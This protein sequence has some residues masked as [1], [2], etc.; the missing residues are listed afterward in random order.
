MLGLSIW[1]GVAGA[2]SG[3]VVSGEEGFGGAVSAGVAS[4]AVI[5]AAYAGAI[6]ASRVLV[7]AAGIVASQEPVTVSVR[8]EAMGRA[9][10]VAMGGIATTIEA[11]GMRFLGGYR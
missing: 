9:T 8:A 10:S 1:L 5:A 7:S 6:V 11:T 2:A 3:A 4:A